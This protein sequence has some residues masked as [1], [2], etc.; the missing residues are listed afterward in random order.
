MGIAICL[1]RAE[2]RLTGAKPPAYASAAS[3]CRG[4]AAA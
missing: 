3:A 4:G 2:A 1:L